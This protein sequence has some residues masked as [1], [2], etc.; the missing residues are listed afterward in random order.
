MEGAKQALGKALKLR[1]RFPG[2]EEARQI[3]AGLK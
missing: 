1:S 3:L 2:S